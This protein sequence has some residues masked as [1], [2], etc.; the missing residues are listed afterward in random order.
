MRDIIVVKKINNNWTKKILGDS[1]EIFIN[2]PWVMFAATVCSLFVFEFIFKHALFIKVPYYF[3]A[4]VCSLFAYW[5]IFFGYTVA[6]DYKTLNCHSSLFVLLGDTLLNMLSFP[7]LKPLSF[8]SGLLAGVATP[9]LI[10]HFNLLSYYPEQMAPTPAMIGMLVFI[11]VSGLFSLRSQDIFMN[12][13]GLVKIIENNK[14]YNSK[15]K[16]DTVVQEYKKVNKDINLKESLILSSLGIVSFTVM[17]NNVLMPVFLIF[18]AMIVNLTYTYSF[19]KTA[20]PRNYNGPWVLT[21]GIIDKLDEDEFS[22][23]IGI[24][25]ED[26]TK[27][28]VQRTKEKKEA[29][30]KESILGEDWY[31]NDR[32][33]VLEDEMEE[34]K[35]ESEEEDDENNPSPS[36][37]PSKNFI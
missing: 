31:L 10:Q 1:K 3:Q 27:K 17:L 8:I 2:S 36:N 18:Y 28:E 33:S 25:S 16:T 21:S 37:T 26:E 6:R 22:S 24:L 32:K 5:F 29:L 12:W 13:D 20:P 19:K 34:E 23:D 11:M 14:Q 15:S 30:S 4:I 7:Y 9:Y 35:P